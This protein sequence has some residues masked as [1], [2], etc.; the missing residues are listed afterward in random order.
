MCGCAVVVSERVGASIVADIGDNGA[1]I[2]AQS[3][4][5]IT[6]AIDRLIAGGSLDASARLR[7]RSWAVAHLSAEAGARSLGEILR[8]IEGKGPRPR[9]FFA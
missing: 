6:D 2:P 4:E 9:P 7:R 3:S 1:V 5:A 8:F